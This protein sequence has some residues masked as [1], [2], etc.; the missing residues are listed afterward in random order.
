MGGGISAESAQGKGSVFRFHVP[1][2][3]K[4]STAA[5]APALAPEPPETMWDSGGRKILVAE[6]NAVNAKLLRILL[7]KLGYQVLQAGDGLQAIETLRAQP[8]CA[9]IFMDVRMPV[10]DGTEAVRRLRLGAASKAGKTIPII[11]LTASVLPA[12]QLAC[13]DAGM[14]HYLTKPFCPEELAATL[15]KA[16]VLT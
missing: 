6:D 5:V 2:V 8:D 10:M 13:I 15:R 14:D 12:D 3:E 11:A 4:S 16:G 7:E 9:A 1:L